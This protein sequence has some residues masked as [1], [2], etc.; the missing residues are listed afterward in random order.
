MNIRQHR[1]SGPSTHILSAILA[2]WLL[3]WRSEW[4]LVDRLQIAFCSV[5]PYIKYHKQATCGC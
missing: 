1:G 3:H 5:Q 4:F 2:S